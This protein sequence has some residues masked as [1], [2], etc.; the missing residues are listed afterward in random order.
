LH[1][2]FSDRSEESEWTVEISNRAM[3]SICG[4][5]GTAD[6]SIAMT[7]DQLVGLAANELT[8]ADV[9]EEANCVGDTTAFEFAFGDL[10]SFFSGFAIVE[11]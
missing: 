8:A 7:F 5:R 2:E 4:R 6:L 3:S 1:L 10:E 11:P 9:I